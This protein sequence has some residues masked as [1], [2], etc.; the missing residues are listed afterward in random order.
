MAQVLLDNEEFY[1]TSTITG[2]FKVTMRSRA[3]TRK[4]NKTESL[5]LHSII[6]C[7]TLL[8]VPIEPRNKIFKDAV[9]TF[10]NSLL[11]DANTTYID[12]FSTPP[13]EHAYRIVKKS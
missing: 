9:S 2:K 12:Y 4:A 1:V 10:A 3:Y 8:G 5:H 11:A 13:H 7:L 6:D